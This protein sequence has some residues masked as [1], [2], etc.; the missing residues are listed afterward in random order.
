MLAEYTHAPLLHLARVPN[1][2]RTLNEE[3]R[4]A[5]HSRSGFRLVL[6]FMQKGYHLDIERIS[7]SRALMPNTTPKAWTTPCITFSEP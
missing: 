1:K 3:A 5:T 7:A 4:S 6:T 2:P